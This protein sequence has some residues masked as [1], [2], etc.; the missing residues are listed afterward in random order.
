MVPRLLQLT[1]YMI[2]ETENDSCGCKLTVFTVIIVIIIVSVKVERIYTLFYY[3]LKVFSWEI[4]A[5]KATLR[6]FTY[7]GIPF[8]SSNKRQ[9]HKISDAFSLVLFF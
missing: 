8:S 9:Y 2:P 3:S 4:C 7:N 1:R 6:I 5:S